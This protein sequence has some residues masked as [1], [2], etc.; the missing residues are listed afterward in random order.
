MDSPDPFSAVPES[1]R[2][3][4]VSIVRDGYAKAD[5]RF[6]EPDGSNGHTYGTDVYY[7]TW[8]GLTSSTELMELGFVFKEELGRKR[9][10]L[11]K[12]VIACHRLGAFVPPNV[13]TDVQASPAVSLRRARQL[14]LPYPGRE[15]E[16]DFDPTCS[17]VI[18]HYG[19][20]E[21]GCLGIYLQVPATGSAKDGV[22][23]A[24]QSLWLPGQEIAGVD[25]TPRVEPTVAAEVITPPVVRRK[26]KEQA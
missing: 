7:M 8:K 11:G 1:A 26:K 6:S 2:R 14:G 3:P 22:W 20:P 13:L 10:L 16:F 21:D 25:D 15:D 5:D 24:A 18:G 9:L 4:L 19:N 17:M 23:A 12:T